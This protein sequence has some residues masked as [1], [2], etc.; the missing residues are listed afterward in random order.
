MV[1]VEMWEQ[2]IQEMDIY[3]HTDDHKQVLPNT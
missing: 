3:L 2:V 1:L